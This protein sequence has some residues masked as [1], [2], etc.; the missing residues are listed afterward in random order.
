M[1]RSKGSLPEDPLERG[2]DGDAVGPLDVVPDDGD[3]VGT[4]HAGSRNVRVLS[5]V[6]IEEQT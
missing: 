5:P 6:R 4:V 1:Q 2:V 3:V